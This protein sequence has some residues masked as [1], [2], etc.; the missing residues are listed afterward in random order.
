MSDIETIQQAM[1]ALEA[2]R[3]LLGDAA[4]DAALTGLRQKL[5]ELQAQAAPAAQRKQVT[6]LFADVSGFT[7][8]SETLDAEEVHDLMNALWERLDA[9]ILQRGGYID[10]HMGD[11]V[12]AIW[13]VHTAREDDAEQCVRTALEM[14]TEL[15]SLTTD[16]PHPVRMRVGVHTG[17]VLLG[18]V[19][20][21]SEFTATGDAVNLTSRLQ[22]AAPVGGVI[23]SHD[24]YRQVRGIFDVQPQ[25]PIT[26][27]G[28][29][30]PVQTY[31][32][33][34]ARPRSFRMATRG[35]EGV[36][37]PMIGR[38]AEL[39]ALQQAFESAMHQAQ[40][41]LVSIVGEAG[42]GKS[43]LL[44]EFESWLDALPE[45]VYLF[46]G[47]ATPEMQSI[48]YG[49]LRSLFSN[50]FD[51]LE[52]D[53]PATVRAK[54]EAG[55]AGSLPPD[56]IA[57]VGQ[58]VGFDFSGTAA[59]QNL[60]GSPSF[61]RLAQAYLVTY[62]RTLASSGALAVFM[63][64]IHWAD[65]SSL[66]LLE[67]LT[68]SLPDQRLMIICLTRPILF[69][70]R[71]DWGRGPAALRIDLQPLSPEMSRRL[72]GEILHK[73]QNL[74]EPLREL[75]V[76]NAEGNPFYVEELIKTFI[77]NGVIL[78]GEDHWQVQV[79][80][81][82]RAHVPATLTE[83]LQARL[84]GLPRDERD[85][86][87]HAAVVGQTFWDAML[88]AMHA[89]GDTVSDTAPLLAKLQWRELI[90]Q[91]MRSTFAGAQ[92][93]TFKHSML[94]EA[95]YETVL[96]KLRRIY[97]RQVAEWMEDSAGER[98]PE[99]AAVIA[100]HYELAGEPAR[101]AAW[102]RRLGD[103][104]LRTGAA[105]ESIA[106]FEHA[107]T[108]LPPDHLNERTA[109]QIRLGNALERTGD[110]DPAA[111]HLQQALADSQHL[112]AHDLMAEATL[113]L[114]RVRMR[115]GEYD[116]AVQLVQAALAQTP[117]PALQAQARRVLGVIAYYQAEYPQA[118][119]Q[120]TAALALEEQ[121]ENRAGA[122]TCLSN[123]G[124]VA[125][126][127]GDYPASIRYFE[128]SLGIHRQLGDRAGIST[129]LGNLGM[130]YED[131]ADLA[132]AQQMYAEALQIAH[133]IGDR[134]AE[135]STLNSLGSVALSQD[136]LNAA[137]SYFES[138]LALARQVN[139]PMLSTRILMNM[140]WAS[141]L[142][143]DYAAS[144]RYSE[145]SLALAEELGDRESVISCLTNLGHAA[146]PEGDWPAAGGYYRRSIVEA[147]KIGALP[148]LLEALAGL[149]GCCW[150]G[151]QPER[152][153][154]L[155]GLALNHPATNSDV[156]Q[157]AD[158]VL[159][160]LQ[161]AL[162]AAGLQTALARGQTLDLEATVESVLAESRG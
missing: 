43:R 119:E 64:D 114:G 66:D 28:K 75:I 133:E 65:A 159:P 98:L 153:A 120:I 7:A 111:E 102:L 95:A 24:A 2:Q 57:L 122:A 37:T 56:Q 32:V 15:N 90:F 93:N 115:Q 151:G 5:A 89:P 27:K 82:Q 154:E 61:A 132:A 140:S 128:Q 9:L 41:R 6:I 3:A 54:F 30:E 31:I 39:A 33:Q 103:D 88:K 52:S 156:T 117:D 147:R 108:L 60:L 79:E 21:T 109:L 11:A 113:G 94:R 17:P 100:R 44:I 50:R 135:C 116:E 78:Q 106:A 36:Q 141:L 4:V 136:D 22:N 49:I 69:E 104:A 70:R 84:D 19:G 8:L 127:Q 51:I 134:R 38:E 142:H 23:I 99:F 35:V 34:R 16:W 96:L 138:A 10:K 118:V 26:L 18:L 105:P 86:L 71:E 121:T 148:R 112:Q 48:P 123:L 107:L 101:A 110:Y 91:Q 87:Q 42:I 144:R 53:R 40:A 55:M 158:F 45:R 149:A 125:L 130:V 58:L 92:E 47:R 85:L 73:V 126:S 80:Q 81:L 74:P 77:E 62:F 25:E 59:V 1:A 97:H 13:G 143:Q 83:L 137:L 76:Q 152:A 124:L 72:V 68:A 157:A 145:E 67:N 129:A 146:W 29:R 162:P 63:E 20:T 139:D 160:H 131:Q 155:L 161:A 150:V 46:Q 12:M 14:Q